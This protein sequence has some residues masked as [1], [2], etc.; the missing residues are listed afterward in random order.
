[1]LGLA[2]FPVRAISVTVTELEKLVNA[3]AIRVTQRVNMGGFDRQKNVPRERN[4]GGHLVRSA[5]RTWTA[6]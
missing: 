1:L 5:N 4:R 6:L 3:T 2:F